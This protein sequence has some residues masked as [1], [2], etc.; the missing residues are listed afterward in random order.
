MW[1][2]QMQN[3]IYPVLVWTPD[4]AR[5]ATRLITTVCQLKWNVA[6]SVDYLYAIQTSCSSLKD[7]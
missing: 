5:K 1:Q 2:I 4:N 7:L 6:I 3:V